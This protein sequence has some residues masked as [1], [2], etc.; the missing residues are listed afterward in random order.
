MHKLFC[1]KYTLAKILTSFATLACVVAANTQCFYIYH[2]E[3][4]PAELT[5][6]KKRK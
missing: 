1:K 4:K 2:Q 3:K 6:F 5:S